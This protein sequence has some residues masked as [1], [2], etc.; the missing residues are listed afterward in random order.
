[1]HATQV[2]MSP[3]QAS[4]LFPSASFSILIT[5]NIY[6]C[7]YTSHTCTLN[8]WKFIWGTHNKFFLGGKL[9]IYK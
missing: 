6:I 2:N 8:T 1:M 3:I 5:W 9:S 7:T 4:D